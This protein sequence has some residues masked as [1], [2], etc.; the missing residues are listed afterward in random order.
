MADAEPT[1]EDRAEVVDAGFL[2]V[3]EAQMRASFLTDAGLEAR[4]ADTASA[5]LVRTLESVPP[6]Q[7]KALLN[8]A[9]ETVYQVDRDRI[10]LAAMSIMGTKALR[11]IRA[12]RAVLASGFES[13]ARALDRILVELM[14]HRGAIL[15]DRTAS[16]AMAWLRRKRKYGI[17]KR[18]AAM[19]NREVYE[20]LC[21]DAHGDPEAVLRLRDPETNTIELGPQR[22]PGTRASLLLYAGFA[23]D[24]AGLVAE[25]SDTTSIQGMDRLDAGIDAA[26]QR[27]KS[28]S[29]A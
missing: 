1:F 16:E 2:E 14:A 10:V 13:E 28:E 20:N 25:L 22:G 9:G 19:G 27:L 17:S 6:G 15:D 3:A 24:H 5:L 8:E 4:L 21:V 23:R 11:V 26:W 12:A 29:G 18:V 7:G